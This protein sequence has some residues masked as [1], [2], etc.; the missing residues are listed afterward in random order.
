[1]ITAQQLRRLGY[2][3]D[4]IEDRISDFADHQHDEAQD[5]ALEEKY[6]TPTR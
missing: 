1:M 6:E 2:S 3:E 4:E 5:R